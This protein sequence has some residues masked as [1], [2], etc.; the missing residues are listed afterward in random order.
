M[1]TPAKRSDD[2]PVHVACRHQRRTGIDAIHLAGRGQL[3]CLHPCIRAA[4]RLRHLARHHA[5][6]GQPRGVERHAHLLRLP[7]HDERLR[8]VGDRANLVLEV[9]G[10]LP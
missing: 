2:H 7:A 6:R 1:K 8:H 10:D 3:A 4:E 9:H 5:T